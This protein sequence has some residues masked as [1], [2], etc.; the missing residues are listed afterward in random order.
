[1]V[2]GICA[3]VTYTRTP[4]QVAQRYEAVYK[5]SMYAMLL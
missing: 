4:E 2:G 3:T 1:M 5:S